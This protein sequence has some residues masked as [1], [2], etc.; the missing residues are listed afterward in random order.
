[1][2][3]ARSAVSIVRWI[4]GVAWAILTFFSSS[5]AQPVCVG[6]C[7]GTLRV[8][9]SDLVLGVNAALLRAPMDACPSLDDDGNGSVAIDELI[10]AV[11]NSVRGCPLPVRCGDALL[12]G[13]E[14]C[15]DG[16]SFNGDG[17][18]A[19]CEFELPPVVDQS[20]LGAPAFC[21]LTEFAFLGVKT[22]V[23]Q[24][25]TPARRSLVRVEV[26][27][28]GRA[29]E[30][31]QS[32]VTLRIRSGDIHGEVVGEREALTDAAEARGSFLQ[33]FDFSPPLTLFPG[34][35]Y[36]V[37]IVAPDASLLWER[38]EGQG[39]CSPSEYPGGGPILS[40]TTDNGPDF[41]FRTF[42]PAPSD[43]CG[44]GR[45]DASEECDDGNVVEG[46]G[47][48]AQCDV[49][50]S[51]VV[52]QS[53]FPE[54]GC[55][56]VLGGADVRLEAPVG[57]EFLPMRNR[58]SAI[59]V[60]LDGSQLS[61]GGVALTLRVREDAIGGTVVGESEVLIDAEQAGEIFVQRF[62]LFPPAVLLP[63]APYV[64]EL[65]ASQAGVLWERAEGGKD[66]ALTEYP[67]GRPIVESDPDDPSFDFLFRTFAPPPPPDC[68]DGVLA[69]T[70]KCDD[71]NVVDGDGC[72]ALCTLEVIGVV[73][74]SWLGPPE[75]CSQAEGAISPV[76]ASPMGQEFT[77]A[78]DELSGVEVGLT[79]FGGTDRQRTLSLLVRAGTIDGPILGEADVLINTLLLRSE[80]FV[81]FQFSPPLPLTPDAVHVLQL[82]TVA[83]ELLWL[84]VFGGQSCSIGNYPD[85]QPIEFG[86]PAGAGLYPWDF[87]FRTFAP[88]E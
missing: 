54:E 47:C 24:E 39:S 48:D 72:T 16:N 46:D 27:L 22:A 1:M 84:R 6:D 13:E 74:Q 36:V 34:A 14:E 86:E 38:E 56:H 76:E 65:A 12:A 17:C 83:P 68:G 67:F 50:P 52:D 70:E 60:R 35:L 80:L 15:D 69:G 64:I 29:F 31:I 26:G 7:D 87:L 23:G 82:T 49:E 19:A 58:L 41:I 57:Q 30:P 5:V 28:R 42:A 33:G 37:E 81:R 75:G 61:S 51:P 2:M 20:W 4:V 53:W 32:R 9:V 55:S 59:E 21:D 71:G 45:V 10:T 79:V 66:C 11:D 63:D 25:F 77:P 73:D 85:G 8:E 43:G 44:D 62:E 40:G 3:R 78:S 88:F 18:S